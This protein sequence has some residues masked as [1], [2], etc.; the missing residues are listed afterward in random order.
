[1]EKHIVTGIYNKEIYIAVIE[2]GKVRRWDVLRPVSADDLEARRE[3]DNIREHCKELWQ[4]AVASG[5][6]EDSLDTY[7][8]ELIDE[9][10]MDNDEEMYPCKDDSDCEYLTG[11][12]R[13][14]ADA[15]MLEH[16][17][18]EIGTWESSGC[19][20]PTTTWRRDDPEF[21]NWDYVFSTPAAKEQA[22]AFV[23]SLKK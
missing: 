11:D 23:Q 10:D 19:Y 6:Y 22:E 8:D 5:Q 16:E 17:D 15:F 2:D 14:E 18:F 20:A 12:L 4:Q 21:K 13:E 3:P 7:V 9:C 1:M